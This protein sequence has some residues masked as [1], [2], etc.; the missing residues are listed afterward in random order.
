MRARTA[1]KYRF[2]NDES[3]LCR[4]GN[5]ADASTDLDR[6]NA[7]CS[8]G[9]GGAA[10]VGSYEANGFGLHDIHGNLL[11]WVADCWNGGDAGAPADGSAWVSGFCGQRVLRGGSWLH[12]PRNLRIANRYWFPAYYPAFNSGFRV[13]RTLT[14]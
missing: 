8:D 14:P 2:G 1:T 6:R 11:E 4:F 12:S 7:S 13:A 9:V 3:A 10:P 5:H